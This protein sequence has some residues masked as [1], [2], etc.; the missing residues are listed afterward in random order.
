MVT[1]CDVCVSA[2]CGPT[3]ICSGTVGE[4]LDREF[5]MARVYE[6]TWMY[7]HI[8]GVPLQ[9]TYSYDISSFLSINLNDKT[10][11]EY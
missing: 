8:A 3:Q 9:R 4:Y 10:T 5:N 1:N 11:Q 6:C 2:P 7:K